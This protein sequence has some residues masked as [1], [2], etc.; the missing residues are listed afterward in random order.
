MSDI[1]L[2]CDT[3]WTRPGVSRW[4]RLVWRQLPQP[5]PGRRLKGR[6]DWQRLEGR[7]ARRRLEGRQ[8]R[9]RLEGR[10]ARWWLKGRQARRRR[11]GR[12]LLCQAPEPMLGRRMEELQAL[13]SG[14]R[15][16]GAILWFETHCQ[17]APH[18]D[19]RG[20]PSA[21]EGRL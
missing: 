16:A 14:F 11:E 3:P 13:F 18:L 10:Q 8:T 12:L 7:Q 1:K 4:W 2:G 15:Q 9:G 20:A 5:L 19:T 6:Q 21:R 17:S